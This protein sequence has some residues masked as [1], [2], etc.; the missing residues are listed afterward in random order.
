MTMFK[1]HISLFSQFIHGTYREYK[2][3]SLKT[4]I[5]MTKIQ[6]CPLCRSPMNRLYERFADPETK[7][8]VWIGAGWRCTNPACNQ[9]I[10]D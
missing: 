2:Y 9:I 1:S 4:D 10:Q 7:K 5:P 3:T 6:L 8:R